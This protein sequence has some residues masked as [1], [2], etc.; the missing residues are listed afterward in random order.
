MVGIKILNR[1][2]QFVNKIGHPYL[3]VHISESQQVCQNSVKGSESSLSDRA[4]KRATK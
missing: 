3:K 1:G 4:K 2:V